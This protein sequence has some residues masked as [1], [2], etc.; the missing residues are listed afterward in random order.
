MTEFYID[1]E[2]HVERKYGVKSVWNRLFV[3]TNDP[4]QLKHFF[5]RVVGYALEERQVEK[6]TE[7]FCFVWICASELFR[8]KNEGAKMLKPNI[9]RAV[10]AD[11]KKTLNLF[12]DPNDF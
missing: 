10:I 4:V 11:I 8:S 1:G 9:S 6:D 7:G 12:K 5:D 2:N 3:N